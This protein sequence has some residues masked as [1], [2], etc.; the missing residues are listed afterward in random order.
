MQRN[1]YISALCVIG[2]LSVVISFPQ[3][4][5]PAIKKLGIFVPAIYGSIMALQFMAFVGVWYFK[6][7]GVLLLLASFI[8]KIIFCLLTNQLAF[9]FYFTISFFVLSC[10]LLLKKFKLMDRNL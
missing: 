1:K 2:Y 4:F 7:W 3:V 9:G 6:Q 8:T 5:S 10:F